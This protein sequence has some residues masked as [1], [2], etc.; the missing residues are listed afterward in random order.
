MRCDHRFLAAG[1]YHIL[2]Q[3]YSWPRKLPGLGPMTSELT[4]TIDIGRASA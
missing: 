3:R 1:E 4:N 2:E